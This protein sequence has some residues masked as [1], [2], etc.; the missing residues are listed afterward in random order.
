MRELVPSLPRFVAVY[1]LFD[2]GN[3]IFSFA[4][5]GAGDTRFV[6]RVALGLSTGVLVLP[7]WLILGNGTL[8]IVCTLLCP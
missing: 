4:M 6:T 8:W 7:T 2:C 1:C 3:L 5:R